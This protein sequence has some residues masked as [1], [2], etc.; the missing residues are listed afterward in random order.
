MWLEFQAGYAT[1]FD[2]S[3]L[4]YNVRAKTRRRKY[5]QTV[6]FVQKEKKEDN[7]MLL[8][9]TGCTQH[10]VADHFSATERQKTRQVYTQNVCEASSY[11][12]KHY[13]DIKNLSWR[14]CVLH[15]RKKKRW[16][17]VHSLKATPVALNISLCWRNKKKLWQQG[18][19]RV[20]LYKE[21]TS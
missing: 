9:C 8:L 14:L 12:V 1:S 6:R 3:S 10:H 18:I 16:D 20:P 15:N 21:L 5:W 11:K 2:D 19:S 4:K 13:P 7:R 17:V